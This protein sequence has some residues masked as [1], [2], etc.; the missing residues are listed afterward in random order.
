MIFHD[1]SHVSRHLCHG[2]GENGL[3][4]AITLGAQAIA[5]LEVALALEFELYKIV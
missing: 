3:I 1:L 4:E 2:R 5:K